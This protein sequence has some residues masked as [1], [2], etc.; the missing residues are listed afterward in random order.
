MEK[1]ECLE[2]LK[3]LLENSKDMSQE[4]GDVWAKDVEAL[5]MAI[6]SVAGV[7]MA[8]WNARI[9]REGIKGTEIDGAKVMTACTVEILQHIQKLTNNFGQFSGVCLVAALRKLESLV[10]AALATEGDTKAEVIGVADDLCGFI[11][12]GFMVTPQEVEM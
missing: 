3:G 10:L 12:C 11:Q 9:F 6:K 1:H 7:D 4:E 2:Q 8:A 5:Q